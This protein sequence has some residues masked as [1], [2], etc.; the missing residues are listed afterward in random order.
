LPR[1]AL[2]WSFRRHSLKETAEA[3]FSRLQRQPHAEW[4]EKPQAALVPTILDKHHPATTI[5][6]AVMG[7]IALVLPRGSGRA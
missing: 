7:W 1:T 2:P 4:Q 6:V 5:S 3:N